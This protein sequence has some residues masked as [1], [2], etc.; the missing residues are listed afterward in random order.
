MPKLAAKVRKQVAKAES[1]SGEFEPFPPG[2]YIATLSQ[3]EAKVSG[4][5]NAMWSLEFDNIKNLDGDD[6]PGRLWSN[7]MLPVDE[8][9]EDYKPKNSKKSPADAWE[10]YQSLVLGRIK[11]FFEA[12]GFT[13]DS[14]TDEMIGERCVLQVGIR[15]INSGPK[16][17]QQSNE[18]NAI[19]P[20]DSVDFEDSDSEDGE[21]GF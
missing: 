6:M 5:G 15:T 21:D 7:L 2:K 3:V 9:P 12:F 1:V 4:N 13:E 10:T 18:V 19:L 11:A 16:K 20:F 8:M 14:D 17:G